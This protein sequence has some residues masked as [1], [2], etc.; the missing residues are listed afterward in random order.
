MPDTTQ[1]IQLAIKADPDDVWNALVD[2]TRTPAYYIGFEAHFDL[3]PGRSYRYTADGQDVITGRVLDVQPR[4]LL[5]TT[6]NGHWAPD[7]DALPESTVTFTV[8]EPFMPMPGVTFLS[9]VH[10]GLPDTEAA[11][12]LE[13]GWVAI[14]SGLKTVLETGS[15]LAHAPSAPAGASPTTSPLT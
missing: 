7:V 11:A 6:F 15:P 3:E 10:E 1:T 2:G 14:L 4:R 13:I 12:H 9:C 8:F 5:R